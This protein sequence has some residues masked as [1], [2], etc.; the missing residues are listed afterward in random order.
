MIWFALRIPT[1]ESVVCLTH[2]WRKLHN[3]I[4]NVGNIYDRTQAM[5]SECDCK[6]RIDFKMTYESKTIYK[7]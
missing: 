3:Q 5:A 2:L 6:I 4:R 1:N 7:L